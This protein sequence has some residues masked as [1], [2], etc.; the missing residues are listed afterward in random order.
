MNAT[1]PP[2]RSPQPTRSLGS[3]ARIEPRVSWGPGRG[4]LGPLRPLR[5][6][7][8]ELLF[9]RFG[10]G[11]SALGVNLTPPPPK[12]NK[13]EKKTRTTGVPR[14]LH[15]ASVDF[16][17]FSVHMCLRSARR[18]I[19]VCSRVSCYAWALVHVALHVRS[20]CALM[21]LP[22][23]RTRPSWF[24]RTLGVW[25]PCIL[26]CMCARRVLSCILLLRMLPDEPL[27]M[28]SGTTTQNK[29]ECH[30]KKIG[31][32]KE[33]E[34]SLITQ[35]KRREKTRLDR[36]RS[37]PSFSSCPTPSSWRLG[38]QAGGSYHASTPG[39]LEKNR[40][41]VATNGPSMCG[42][43]SFRTPKM[44]AVCPFWDCFL[45]AQTT[46]PLLSVFPP[47]GHTKNNAK[48]RSPF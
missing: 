33:K 32:K 7:D 23:G 26:R 14:A 48:V 8:E 47:L 39:D 16:K 35:K 42:S 9:S 43:S 15:R 27:A 28:L 29:L 21:S 1:S 12:K 2:R 46:C 17:H 36:P 31:K 4:T 10:R 45:L 11:S 38:L 25:L 18:L 30:P 37:A 13:E 34:Q 44:A 3:V 41:K 6:R 22:T 5:P 24:V 19:D 40:A 20:T